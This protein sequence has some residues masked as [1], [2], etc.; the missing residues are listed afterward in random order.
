MVQGQQATV[1]PVQM[2][3]NSVCCDAM[4]EPAEMAPPSF[5]QA[6]MRFPVQFI[7]EAT[8]LRGRR[9]ARCYGN[10]SHRKIAPL[11]TK[12]TYIVTDPL[13]RMRHGFVNR[14]PTDSHFYAACG[15]RHEPSMIPKAL[16][17]ATL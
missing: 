6:V 12:I 14:S 5:Q 3:F 8:E 16:K 1:L 7:G 2:A 4:H 9:E 11:V 15:S 13:D 17:I 10:H